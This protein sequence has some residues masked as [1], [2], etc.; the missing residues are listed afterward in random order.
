MDSQTWLTALEYAKA[1]GIPY[2]AVRRAWLHSPPAPGQNIEGW[3]VRYASQWC[4]SLV[5]RFRLCVGPPGLGTYVSY[6]V[7]CGY[8]PQTA[9]KLWVRRVYQESCSSM[10]EMN[11]LT[12]SGWD[13]IDRQYNNAPPMPERVSHEEGKKLLA[14]IL[15]D[16]KEFLMRHCIT[17][18]NKVTEERPNN[19]PAKEEVNIP[20]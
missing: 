13:L 8:D 10:E 12:E 20:F 3:V 18:N 14:E 16:I 7:M 15:S 5:K 1:H 2:E 4:A 9:Y 19:K 6:A 11:F 17:S